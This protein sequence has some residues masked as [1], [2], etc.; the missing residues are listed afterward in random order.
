M[1]GEASAHSLNESNPQLK[2]KTEEVTGYDNAKKQRISKAAVDDKESPP[3]GIL[4]DNK[5]LLKG[6]SLSLKRRSEDGPEYH[7]VQKPKPSEGWPEFTPIARDD[8]QKAGLI[9]TRSVDMISPEQQEINR[10][11]DEAYGELLADWRRRTLER[12]L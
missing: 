9:G 12:G 8:F 3:S 6:R 5:Q 1:T 10:S 7:A 11:T 4:E 2:C